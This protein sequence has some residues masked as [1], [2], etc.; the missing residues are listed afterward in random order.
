MAL[1]KKMMRFPSDLVSFSTKL[2]SKSHEKFHVIFVTGLFF[3]FCTRGD[4]NPVKNV[5]LIF[6]FCLFDG[7]LVENETKADKN[8]ITFLANAMEI[9]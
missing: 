8:P 3:L 1:A 6:S 4:C 2:P 7:S 5:T 9:P